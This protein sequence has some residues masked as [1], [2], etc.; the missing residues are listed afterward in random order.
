M[1][2]FIFNFIRRKN[3]QQKKTQT[4]VLQYNNFV[5]SSF[6]VANVLSSRCL[7]I[8]NIYISFNSF[9]QCTRTDDLSV[10]NKENCVQPYRLTTEIIF[11]LLIQSQPDFVF[12]G[13][14][15]HGGARGF[16]M[17]CSE[18][19]D[20]RETAFIKYF[21]LLF[22]FIIYRGVYKYEF[23]SVQELACMRVSD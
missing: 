23:V 18:R 8:I 1:K 5:F 10:G 4:R 6:V 17:V 21:A 15:S 12:M 7:I 22:T 14:L 13:F 3:R 9:Y 19:S 11:F 16:K 2:S 20:I